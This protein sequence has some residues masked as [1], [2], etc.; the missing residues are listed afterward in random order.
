MTPSTSTD[1]VNKLREARRAAGLVR[2]EFY[3]PRELADKVAAAVEKI[4]EGEES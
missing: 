2:K 1:R 4:I 3:V